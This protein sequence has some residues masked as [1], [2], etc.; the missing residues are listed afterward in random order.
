MT[1]LDVDTSHILEVACVITDNNLKIVSQDLNIV[2]HQPDEILE[3]MSKW[4]VEVH[5]KV[6]KYFRFY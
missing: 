5:K 6:C 4:C 1:G 2:I 3:N